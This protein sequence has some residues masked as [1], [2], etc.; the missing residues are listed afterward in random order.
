MPQADPPQRPHKATTDTQIVQTASKISSLS[1][2]V[3]GCFVVMVFSP[4]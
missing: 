1:L 2:N 3:N 4:F